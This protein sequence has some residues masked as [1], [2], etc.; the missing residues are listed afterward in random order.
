M[1]IHTCSLPASDWTLACRR[2]GT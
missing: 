1:N 2:C